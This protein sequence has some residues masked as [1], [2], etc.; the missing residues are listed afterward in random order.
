MWVQST[1]LDT[2]CLRCVLILSFNICLDHPRSLHPWD[3]S[4]KTSIHFFLVPYVPHVTIN[5]M[6]PDLI[7]RMV[8]GEEY[9]WWSY[10]GEQ[11]TGLSIYLG[12]YVNVV[13]V[14]HRLL[15][16]LL[17]DFLHFSRYF[18]SLLTLTKWMLCSLWC[19][20]DLHVEGCSLGLFCIRK[21]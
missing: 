16:F 4:N 11:W 18:W 9:R 14:K 17:Y 2:T 12:M 10:K 20:H 1:C 7:V 15:N 21:I 8:F 6:L 3:F 13:L 19:K 5:F